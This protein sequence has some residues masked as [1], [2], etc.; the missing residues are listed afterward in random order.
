MHKLFP[1]LLVALAPP[2]IAAQ[3]Q[4]WNAD[5]IN[6]PQVWRVARGANVN[7]VV[8]DTGLDFNHEDLKPAFAGGY[9][10]I[11]PAQPAFDDNRHGTHV[12]G[13]IA[14]ADNDLGIKG[15]APA[16]K[17]WG[18]KIFDAQGVGTEENVIA[19]LNWIIEQK[20]ARGGNWIANMSFSDESPMSAAGVDAIR[21]AYAAG[22]LLVAAS[23]IA[24]STVGYPAALPEVISVGAVD[25][26][27]KRPD[28]SAYGPGLLLVAPG[29]EVMS[30]VTTNSVP[31]STLK[32][33]GEF[34]MRVRIVAGSHRVP[35]TA[36]MIDCGSGRENE[37][38]AT[39]RGGIALVQRSEL[40]FT[41]Q[42]RNAMNAG[43]IGVVI[44]NS[45]ESG[46]A[47]WALDEGNS[48]PAVGAITNLDGAIARRHSGEIVTLTIRCDD[49]GRL[50]G[51]SQAA[52]HVSAAAALLW[53]LKPS[54][55]PQELREVL[56]ETARDLGPPGYDIEYGN[57]LIDVN[58]AA[59]MLA[60]E[61]FESGR[62]RP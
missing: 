56:I 57:G 61:S 34:A 51:T 36:R 33:D 43:A 54:A 45:D 21:H 41:Q 55:T 11:D 10:T 52:P 28:I 18:V 30:L 27:D 15:I 42:V 60:P 58:A 62:R 3:Q 4:T 6:A 26:N 25:I 46:I 24:T 35:L 53:S 12:A 59:R 23:G 39:V 19:A 29:V 31:A 38:P 32:I 50:T 14:A 1:L 9:N 49:Y 47:R 8:I 17:L 20:A 48:W 13:I 37:F 40:T 22:I 16:V 7:V 2:L 5:A 44:A